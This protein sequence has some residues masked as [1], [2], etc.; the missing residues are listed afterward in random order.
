MIFSWIY[1]KEETTLM[2]T[3]LRSKGISKSL[4]ATIKFDGGSIWLNGKERTVLATLEKDDKVMIRIPDEGEHETTVGVDMPLDILFEDDHF[5][6]VNKPFG[7]A[8]I[9]SKVHPRLSMANRVK[10]YYQRQ[11]YVDQVIHIVT[12][13]DRDT[14]GVML[15]ARHG[16]A[17]ALMDTLLRNKEVDKTYRAVLSEPVLT[18]THGFIDA[19]IGRTEDSIITRMVREDG[20]QALT[21]YWLDKSYPDGQTV[22]IKLHTGRT[23]QIRVHFTSIGAPL[24]GDDLYGGKADPDMLRQALH[25]ES[26]AFVH[27]ISGEPLKIEAPLPDDFIKWESRQRD[28]EA[29]IHVGTTI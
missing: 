11:G 14:T 21:E 22:K 23:H 4:L 24:L 6:V 18:E 16:Y 3:F 15:F 19:P 27:P 10:G 28:K 12:R 26:L 5:L 20:K 13:L 1:E 7:A 25:C 8:S 29:E 9:P 17:H 2:K